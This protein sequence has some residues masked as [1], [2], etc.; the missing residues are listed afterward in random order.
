[1]CGRFTLRA[2][3]ERVR[4]EFQ[5]G[6]EPIVEALDLAAEVERAARGWLE[7]RRQRVR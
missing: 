7:R 2:P 6:E 3:K 5:L 4:R 1:M